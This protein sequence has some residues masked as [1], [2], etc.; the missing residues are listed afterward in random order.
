MVSRQIHDEGGDAII[1][2][3]GNCRSCHR[4]LSISGSHRS[5]NIQRHTQAS[6]QMD[7]TYSLYF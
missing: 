3:R 6:L 1:M 5:Q 7:L 2:I 4:L